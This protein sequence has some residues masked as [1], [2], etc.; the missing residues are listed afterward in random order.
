MKILFAGG[1]LSPALAL[2]DYLKEKKDIKIIFV[3]RKYNSDF[4]K[5]LSLEFKEIKKR[6]IKF[7]HLPTGRLTRIFN[8]NTLVN[9]LKI[10]WG[11]VVALKI[12]KDEKPDLVFS[13]GGYLAFPIALWAFVFKIPLYIHEQTINPGLANRLIGLI[14][15][16]VFISFEETK[17]YF[18]AN[19]TIYTGIPLK[20]TIF[21]VIRKPFSLS[22]IKKRKIFVMGG[23]L[24]SHSI[25]LIIEKNL[26]SLKKKY[27]IVHQVGNVK[28]YHDFERLQKQAD[29]NYYVTEHFFDDE[30]GYIYKNVDLIISRAGAN[31]FFELIALKKP[32]ILIPLPW[33]ANNE[34]LKQAQLF[35]RLGLG[36]VFLQNEKQ[37][38]LIAVIEKVFKDYH[39]HKRNFDCLPIKFSFNATE[40]IINYIL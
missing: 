28:K 22:D 39:K 8:F 11:I 31:T 25:N 37:E 36:Y 10:P 24:G 9:L 7:H 40:K 12:I 19:K 33:S 13:F 21:K 38:K 34:Q 29:E 26:T 32:A 30:I 3:G 1:H 16:K 18:P 20:S 5:S 35:Q 17:K 27:M 23:S 15:K 4:D 14:A 6:K 2:I